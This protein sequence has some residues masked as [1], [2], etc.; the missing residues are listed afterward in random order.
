MTYVRA[1]VAVLVLSGAALGAADV[2]TI[3][4]LVVGDPDHPSSFVVDGLVAMSDKVALGFHVATDG[5]R[6][7]SVVFDRADGAPVLLSDG[8]RTLLLDVFNS[9]V[10]LIRPSRTHVRVDWNADEPKPL[11]FEFQ[12]H[13]NSDPRELKANNS[14]FRVDRFVAGSRAALRPLDA[15]A[16]SG[17]AA[18]RGEYVETVHVPADAGAEPKAF[19]FGSLKKGNDYY[20]LSL[21]ARHVGAAVPAEALRFPDVEQLRKEIPVEEADPG[22]VKGFVQMMAGGHGLAVKLALS[23]D[24]P[25]PP[26]LKEAFPAIDWEPLRARD[27]KLF[28]AY[29]AAMEK[30]GVVYRAPESPKPAGRPNDA[31]PGR[32]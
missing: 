26:P 1:M 20:S 5:R 4:P 27:A 11:A 15:G 10:L 2:P 31:T 21:D 30:Q 24:G 6:E 14:Y 18:D 17:F 22:A 28:A 19:R 12:M 3:P 16:W 29:R 25:V 7:L 23:G 13:A 9:R 32:K 8:S